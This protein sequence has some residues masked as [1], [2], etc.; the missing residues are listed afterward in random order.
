MTRWRTP[1]YRHPEWLQSL[2]GPVIFWVPT[3]DPRH[4]LPS[5]KINLSLCDIQ[6]I[7]ETGSN[8]EIRRKLCVSWL[9]TLATVLMMCFLS[10]YCRFLCWL[11]HL[12]ALTP[13]PIHA[14]PRSLPRTPAHTRTRAHYRTRWRNSQRSY[15]ICSVWQLMLGEPTNAWS[16]KKLFNVNQRWLLCCVAIP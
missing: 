5:H 6:V 13:A 10:F 15:H 16:S 7:S 2:S 4:W 12:S 3:S 9:V 8:G 1:P 11:S 14:H